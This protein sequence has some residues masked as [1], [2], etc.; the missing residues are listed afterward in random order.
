MKFD[1][2]KLKEILE[3]MGFV[4][5]HE[6][7]ERAFHF[8]ISPDNKFLEYL[9]DSRRIRLWPEFWDNC[10]DNYESF[11]EL[12]L[13]KKARHYIESKKKFELAVKMNELKK[14]FV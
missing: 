9:G 7:G 14:D 1:L 4:V 6:F 8:V 12:D 3:P 13:E 11:E 5:K 10:W 2:E